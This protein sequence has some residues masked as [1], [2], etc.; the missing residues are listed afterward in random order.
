MTIADLVVPPRV[1]PLLPVAETVAGDGLVPGLHR[2]VEEELGGAHR[3]HALNP[4]P[5]SPVL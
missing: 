4:A 1:V 2:P 3:Q 5:T